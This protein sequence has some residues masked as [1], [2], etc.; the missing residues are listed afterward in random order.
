MKLSH[1][2]CA[3]GS[4]LLVAA[5]AMAQTTYYVNVNTPCTTACTQDGS[6]WAYAYDDLQEAIT[7]ATSGDEIWIAAGTYYPTGTTSRNIYFDIPGGVSVYG[8][9]DGTESSVGE[10]DPA[11]N[12]TI[13]SGDIDL[14]DVLD[15]GNSYHVVRMTSMSGDILIDGV[16]IRMGRANGGGQY[17]GGGI[18]ATGAGSRVLTLNECTI[19]DNEALF[20]GGG[21][22][23]EDIQLE[24]SDC[25][26]QENATIDTGSSGWGG[27]I[28]SEDG[29]LTVERSTFA[30][31]YAHGRAAGVYLHEGG[32]SRFNRCVFES[33]DSERGSALFT[34]GGGGIH[35]LNSNFIDNTAETTGIIHNH[36]NNNQK[37]INCSFSG[38]SNT[39]ATEAS[40]YTKHSNT[41][42]V[43]LYNNIMWDNTCT[44]GDEIEDDDDI[45]VEDCIV[46][47]GWSGTNQTNVINSDPDWADAQLN[48]SANSPAMQEG[49]NGNITS[50]Y[51][52]YDLD[53]D[54]RIQGVY[55][56][57]GSQEYDCILTDS[58]GITEISCTGGDGA[59]SSN[60]S[61]AGSLTYAWSTGAS[62]SSISSLTAGTYT[63]SVTDSVGCLVISSYELEDPDTVLYVN[64][65]TPCTTACVQDGSD[66]DHAYADLQDAIADVC[67]GGEIWVAAGTYYPTSGTSRSIYFELPGGSSLYGGFDGTETAVGQADPASNVTILSGDLDEDNVMDNSNS[68]HVVYLPSMS[69]DILI[70][71]V[72]VRMGRAN[73]S[74]SNKN[75]GGAIYATGASSRVLT[76][77]EC[78]IEDNEA[79][80][81]GGGVGIDDIQLEIND[82]VF[83]NNA[84]TSSGQG[85]GGAIHSEDGKVTMKRTEVTGNSG[86]ERAGAVY[87]HVSSSSLFDRCFFDDNDADN[88]GCI[89]VEGGG[90][91]QFHNSIFTGNASNTSNA[92]IHNHTSNNLKVV[93]CSFDD[94]STAHASHA[95]CVSK[96]SNTAAVYLYNNIMWGNSS[97]S[98]DE[99]KDDDDIIAEDCIVEGGWSGTNQTNIIDQNP[100]WTGTYLDLTSSSTYA[101]DAGT[102]ANQPYSE[103]YDG[104]DRIYDSSAGGGDDIDLGAQEYQSSSKRGLDEAWSD[105]AFTALEVYPNPT[106]GMIHLN[107][108]SAVK[109]QLFD[110]SGRLII[111]G[112]WGEGHQQLDLSE[113]DAG[114]YYLIVNGAGEQ[115][116]TIMKM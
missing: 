45:T 111:K 50:G 84:A 51:E 5:S 78:I 70:Q 14:D 87:L 77:N 34:E 18:Y 109:Y 59:L 57:L 16:T 103:D 82:C 39:H 98:G 15:N 10:A 62:T 75:Y 24:I 74:G 53:G 17:Y 40:C 86:F 94:N 20:L 101:I 21:T 31:N 69:G 49:T 100:N 61:G 110:A 22:S 108:E 35:V 27:A 23:I 64:V 38:N 47:G 92:I 55:V 26:F 60:A 37:I 79:S 56:D 90:G 46:E 104:D 95:S 114:I 43:Y 3:L 83:D 76:L 97:T 2:M 113:L 72:T 63:L 7:A 30:D 58:L 11:T 52:S 8:G 106:S 42:A 32:G 36:T 80:S 88:G 91:V 65:N 107:V 66:W 48:L 81:R 89:F 33:N 71:G 68:Y 54:D 116:T 4:A 9:F 13:L 44:S 12:V 115:R 96:H 112:N 85:W 67:S 73:G 29:Q 41:A 25:V 105:D 28:H 99:I 93:N 6:A 102:D 19:E 1:T